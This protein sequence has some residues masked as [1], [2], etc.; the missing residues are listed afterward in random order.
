MPVRPRSVRGI[1]TLSPGSSLTATGSSIHCYPAPSLTSSIDRRVAWSRLASARDGRRD[2]HADATVM[3]YNVGA[4]CWAAAARRGLRPVRRGHH[5]LQELALDQGAAIA[6]ILVTTTS[7]SAARHR[8]RTR[9][10]ISS[11]SVLETSSWSCIPA[12]PIYRLSSPRPAATS[13]L[14]RPSTAARIGGTGSVN[15]R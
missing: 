7:S 1:E 9:G 3:T 10:L 15:P 11:L 4:G 5:R 14:R 8:Y 13:R 6:A 2:C 12:A